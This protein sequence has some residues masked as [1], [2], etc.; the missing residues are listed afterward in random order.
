MDAN[1]ATGPDNIPVRLLKETVDVIA[2]SLCNLF[3]KSIRLG[4]FPTEWKTAN[5]CPIHKKDNKQHAENYR[6]ISLL[7]VVSKVMERCVLE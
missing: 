6:P 1:K 5:V 4:K 7:S 2:S 3:N